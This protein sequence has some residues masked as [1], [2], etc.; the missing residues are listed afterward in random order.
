M[1]FWCDDAIATAGILKS[2][3]VEF[4]SDPTFEEIK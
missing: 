4:V 1:T 3:G 2:K